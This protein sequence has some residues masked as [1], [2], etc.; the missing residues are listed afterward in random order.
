GGE[1][2]WY[3]PLVASLP[4]VVML[5]ATVIA[6]RWSLFGGVVFVALGASYIFQFFRR[7]GGDD[8]LGL[9]LMAG[10]PIIAGIIF[11]VTDL[12]KPEEPIGP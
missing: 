1:V 8:Y 9:I 4:G 11:I 10:L 7:D 3:L 2:D 5:I 6:W 12:L